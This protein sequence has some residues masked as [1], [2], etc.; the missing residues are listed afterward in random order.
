[1]KEMSE[2]GDEK[3]K[4]KSEQPHRIDRER[5]GRDGGYERAIRYVQTCASISVAVGQL[6]KL[7]ERKALLEHAG[8]LAAF[9][10]STSNATTTRLQLVHIVRLCGRRSEK[11]RENENK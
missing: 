9:A 7:E 8:C 1:M 3:E 2:G 5:E 10:V 4:K 11:E 6:C